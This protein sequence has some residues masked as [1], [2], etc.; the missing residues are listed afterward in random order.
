[1]PLQQYSE[2]ILSTRNIQ[3]NNW[4]VSS[5]NMLYKKTVQFWDE[6]WD[7]SS[8]IYHCTQARREGEWGGKLPHII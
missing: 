6:I 1:M 3:K 7:Q 8:V 4:H 2:I 5:V